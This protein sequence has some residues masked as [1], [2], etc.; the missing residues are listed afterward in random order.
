[1]ARERNIA[2]SSVSRAISS[3]ENEL[4]VKLF[5]RTTRQL[6]PTEAGVNYYHRVEHLVEELVH[7]GQLVADSDEQ[8][9]GNL[10]ITAPVTFGQILLTPHLPR[11]MERWPEVSVNLMLSDATVDLVNDRI[12]IALR[13]GR[14]PDSSYAARKLGPM[15]MVVCAAPAYL[16][17]YGHPNHPEELAHHNCLRLPLAGYRTRWI[18]R[19]RGE[20]AF[21]VDVHGRCTISNVAALADCAIGGM[22]IVLLPVWSVADALSD[23]RL[24]ALCAD[25]QVTAT[26]F[27]AAVWML[28]PSKEYLP[29]KT[30]AM[31]EFI[32]S[33]CLS[34][35]NPDV[36]EKKS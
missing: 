4:G 17:R 2:P 16:E 24:T 11:F 32:S 36:D 28:Y 34:C 29:L 18:F 22:G 1:M 20:K 19:R 9:K 13:L 12:D 5:Q 23:G 27:E 8:P 15:H 30:L 10:R 35:L 6:S 26:D 31:M 21:G 3:L 7:A 14:L 33:E 25:W